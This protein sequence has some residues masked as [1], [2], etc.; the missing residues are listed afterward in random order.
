MEEKVATCKLIELSSFSSFQYPVS[1]MNK[2]RKQFPLFSD[3]EFV[4]S[5]SLPAGCK[6]APGISLK[7]V[8]SQETGRTEKR[9]NKIKAYTA[10]L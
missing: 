5:S 7:Q 8:K 3:S 4:Q 1:Q 6:S 9:S 10:C 2:M